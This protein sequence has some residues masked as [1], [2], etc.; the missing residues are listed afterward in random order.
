[1]SS[2]PLFKTPSYM[3]KL[4]SRQN[5]KNLIDIIKLLKGGRYTITELA[6]HFNAS[7]RSIYRWMNTI[8]KIGWPVDKDFEDKFFIVEGCCPMCGAASNHIQRRVEVSRPS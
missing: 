2:P 8:D 5:K 3:I 4:R 1:M 7:E 6:D